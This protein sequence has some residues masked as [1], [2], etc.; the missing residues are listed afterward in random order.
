MTEVYSA[1]CWIPGSGNGQCG[2]GGNSAEGQCYNREHSWPKSWW[3]G[4]NN[5][6]Y[7]DIHHVFP[8]DGYVNNRRSNFPYGEV[9]S[10][11]WT[12]SEGNKRGSC[13]SGT[14]FEPT[15]R[16]KGFVA[17]GALYVSVR[18]RGEF[19][20]C[21]NDAVDGAILVASYEALMLRWHAEHPVEDWEMEFNNR[22]ERTQGN[23]NPFIDYPNLANRLFR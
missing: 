12:S 22:A 20:C 9:N 5:K 10:A 3:G 19:S 7:T 16:V 14:C 18:Y 17:R 4:G 11:D 13:S 6:A 21:S 15:D 2:S 1:R 23:R 8:S